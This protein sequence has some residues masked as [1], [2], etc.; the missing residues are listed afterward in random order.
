MS[1]SKC[2]CHCAVSLSCRQMINTFDSDLD[3]V[4]RR[5]RSVEESRDNRL[6]VFGAWVPQALKEID[7]E[8]HRFH[9][10]PIGPLGELLNEC[11]IYHISMLPTV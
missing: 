11:C 5:L 7:R 9:H 3:R 2:N 4:R 10:R 6:K 1:G 8:R